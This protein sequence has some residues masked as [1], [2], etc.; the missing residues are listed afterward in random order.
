MPEALNNN[1]IIVW[2][3]LTTMMS[4]AG[5]QIWK[6]NFMQN[7]GVRTVS[8]MTN[9]VTNDKIFISYHC[10]LHISEFHG[11]NYAHRIST[12]TISIWTLESNSI[13]T[14]VERTLY[15]LFEL[16]SNKYWY[17]K[18]GE[19]VM[20]WSF[21]LYRLHRLSHRPLFG[22]AIKLGFIFRTQPNPCLYE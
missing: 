13:L 17:N 3:P 18:F 19:H 2:S 8:I 20:I 4:A 5:V 22:L 21:S 10:R 6:V 15:L 12:E 14:R 11:V 9:A 16:K 7:S 1:F